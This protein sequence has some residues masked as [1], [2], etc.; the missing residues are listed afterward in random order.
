LTDTN[1]FK[2][3]SIHLPYYNKL[4]TKAKENHR[5]PGQQME[6]LIDKHKK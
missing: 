2:S 1:K 3:V 5:S 6:Y 4:A